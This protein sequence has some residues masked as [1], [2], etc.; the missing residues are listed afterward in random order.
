MV[1]TERLRE[2]TSRIKYTNTHSHR[3][4]GTD[5]QATWR[6]CGVAITVVKQRPFNVSV[7]P[8]PEGVSV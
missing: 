2:F 1:T 8:R 7:S 3:D 6:A 4:A 5:A